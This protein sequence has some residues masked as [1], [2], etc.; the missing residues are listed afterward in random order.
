MAEQPRFLP[1]EVFSVLAAHDVEYVLIGGLAAVL[2]GSPLRTNDADICP[3]TSAA[4]LERLADALVDLNAR[5]ETVDG[6]VEFVCDAAFLERVQVLTLATR[7]G[8]LDLSYRPAGTGGYDDLVRSAVDFDVE[9]V[10]VPTASLEDVIRSK[11]SAGRAKDHQALP[12]LEALANRL[13]DQPPS[14][15]H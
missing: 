1:Q 5:L 13:Q 3:A 4:N 8:R 7:F 11:R 2:H 6:P 14:P 10:V 9:G 15:H 12:T